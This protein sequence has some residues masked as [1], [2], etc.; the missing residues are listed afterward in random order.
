MA[1]LLRR[2][3]A[4]IFD[5]DGV[6]IESEKHY[7]DSF[8]AASD[9]GGHG[10]AVEVYQ[11]VCGSP[12]D[13]I[14]ATIRSEYGDDFPMEA[15]REAWLRHLAIQMA[16]G[17]ALKAGVIEILDLLDKLE[18]PRAIATSSGH[19]SVNRHLGAFDLTRRFDHILARG[20][21]AE[22][23]P[24]PLPYLTAAKRLRFAPEDCLSLE[25]SYHGVQSAWSAGTQTVMVP[26]VAPATDAMREK[27]V[28]IC[29]SLFDVATLLKLA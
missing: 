25:D 17:V 15:F 18:I 21:Y 12:W 8:L 26:D 4:V 14:T 7:R 29:D 23:K 20:D 16:D 11:R 22:P 9:E 28:T 27:C 1:Q 10:M 19:E 6:L 2:P 5:M 3:K 24:S 13:V